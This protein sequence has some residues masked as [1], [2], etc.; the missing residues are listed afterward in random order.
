[1]ATAELAQRNRRVGAIFVGVALAMLGLGYAAVPM[2][3]IFCQATGFNGTPARATEAEA[4][5]VKATGETMEVRFDAN[6]DPGMH[7]MFTPE[8]SLITIP[9]GERRLALF[10]ARND[11][12]RTIIGQA[13]YNIEPE[14]AAK[15]FN[16]IQCF[17]FTQQT[18]AP[19][20]EVSMPVVFYVDP[21]IKQDPDA[22]DVGQITL[23]YTF[24]EFK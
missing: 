9:M 21:K 7:W 3:R 22:S 11:T 13:S 12:D 6:V 19:H 17:C 4:A 2:Y 20:Q 23:S 15:Y 10:R 14:Q 18:L 5:Q 8:Q 1:M 24:H 16:K